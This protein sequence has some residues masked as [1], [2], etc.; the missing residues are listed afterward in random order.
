MRFILPVLLVLLA[1]PANAQCV[2][3]NLLETMPP[4]KRAD[5]EAAI[6]THPY[7]SGNLWRAQRGD[8]TI[9][10][11]GTVHLTDPR[12]DA[13]LAPL[14]PIVATS[15]LILLEGTLE[16]TKQL[17][18]ALLTDRSLMFITDGPTLPD[19]LSPADWQHLSDEMS[20]RGIPGFMASKMQPWFVSMMLAIPP[21]AMASMAAKKGVDQRIM[22]HAQ[23]V[24]IPTRALE[25]YDT[26][27][28]LFASETP[29]EEIETIRL[30]LSTSG[31]A[32]AV[33]ATLADAYFTGRHRLIWELGRLQVEE[34][35]F[36][37][38]REI[39][40]LFNEMEAKV[41]TDR[42]ANWM[43]GILKAASETDSVMVAVGAAHL[44]GEKGLLYLLGQ[45]GYSLSRVDGF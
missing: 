37:P 14:W 16:T 5:L 8:S 13:Y 23:T 1:L 25:P 28:S 18:T 20:A 35:D 22:A 7:P 6:A 11:M 45:A 42:N 17:E 33:I 40:V 31:N 24:N 44:S 34:A 15:D 29:E 4:A 3:K 9:H 21:C 19:R 27:F 26:V 32:E 2:G 36:K 38:S 41:L 43:A 10:I 12:L 39:S 30:G